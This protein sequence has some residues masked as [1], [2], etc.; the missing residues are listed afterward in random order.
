VP[1][2]PIIENDPP[3]NGQLTAIGLV[4]APKSQLKGL[5]RRYPLLR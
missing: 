3:W 2:K 5:L 1:H 4:P